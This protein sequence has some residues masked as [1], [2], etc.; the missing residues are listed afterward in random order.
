MQGDVDHKRGREMWLQK[1]A[2]VRL[3][4]TGPKNRAVS[5]PM[6]SIVLVALRRAS[7]WD[8]CQGPKLKEL[9]SGL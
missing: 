9:W 7:A 4:S 1:A 5:V 6:L 2:T 8:R 3:L